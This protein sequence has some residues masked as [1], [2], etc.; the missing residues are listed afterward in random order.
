M[1]LPARNNE[2]GLVRKRSRLTD[3]Y[4]LFSEGYFVDMLYGERKRTE[5][6]K[7]PFLLMLLNLKRIPQTQRRNE[8]P[9]ISDSLVST[10]REV[11]IKGWF[12]EGSVIGVIFTELNG[13]DTKLAQKSITQKLEKAFQSELTGETV[14]KMEISFHPFPEDKGSNPPKNPFNSLFYPEIKAGKELE[15]IS[16]LIKRVMDIVGS[17]AGILFFC[18]LMVL[19]AILIRITSKGPVFFKQERIGKHGGKFVFL[20]FRSMY[21]NS[22]ESIHKNYVEKLIKGKIVNN[23]NGA[24]KG[25]GTYKMQADP[26]VTPLGKILRKASLDELPQLL[27]VLRGNMS[28]VGPRPPLPYEIEKYDLWHRTRILEVKPGI[29][30]LWQVN[31]RSSTTFDEMVRLDIRYIQNW[32]LFLDLKI[33]LMTP[34]AALS[35][36][37]AY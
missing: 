6:S 35:G 15:G 7:R 30:G 3:E 19:I 32:S 37:G 5:R 9:K 25:N 21:V 29:T 4:G 11:D 2:T 13:G 20:K 34:W 14:R 17:V 10:T 27:N 8:I 24:G 12:E 36:K 23:G 33:L 31:G 18:P 1:N 26:R 16:F 28:L 22:D